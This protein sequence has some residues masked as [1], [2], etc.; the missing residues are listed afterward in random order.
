MA[1]RL[2]IEYPAAE[3]QVQ[4]AAGAILEQVIDLMPQAQGSG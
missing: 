2:D 1:E 4:R 3:W